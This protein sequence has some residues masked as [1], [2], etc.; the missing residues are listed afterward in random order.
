MLALAAL[1]A[2]SGGGIVRAQQPSSLHADI[3][4]VTTV[5]YPNAR[6]VVDVEDASGGTV[7]QLT[8]ANFTAALDG[9]PVPVVAADLASSQNLPV[10]VLFIM[11]VSGSMAGAPIASAKEAAKAF[12]AGLAPADRVA[13]MSF[14]DDVQLLQDYTTDRGQALAAI[15]GLTAGGNTALYRATD[16]AAHKAAASGASRRVAILLS[17][18]AQDGVP[19]TIT[20]EQALAS[21]AG[22]GTPFFTVGEGREIDRAYLEALAAQTKGRYLEAPSPNDLEGLYASIGQLLR[23]QYVV[24]FDAS[25]AKDGSTFALQLQAGG[26]TATATAPF[27][28]GPGFAPP[29]VTVDG[30]KEGDAL[31]GVRTVTASVGARKDANVTFYVD[32]VSVAEVS[33]PPYRYSLDP[34]RLAAG[35]HRLRV[36]VTDATGT[37]PS[38]ASFGFSWAPPTRAAGGGGLPLLPI[39]AAVLACVVLAL[40]AAV[41]LRL[42][43]MRSHGLE[44]AVR[45]LPWTNPVAEA[46][47]AQEPDVPPAVEPENVGEPLGLLISR[48]GSDFGSEYTVGGSPISIG[49]GARCGV[50]V[51]DPDLGAEEARIWVRKGH[52][53]V[54]RMTKLTTVMNQGGTG[55]WAILE[56]GDSFDIGEHRF[57]FQLLQPEQPEEPAHDIPNVLRDPDVPHR[58]APAGEAAPPPLRSPRTSTFSELMPRNDWGNNAD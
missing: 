20:S 16:E 5:E 28:A 23:S 8:A 4:S 31:S 32:S 45:I 7:Q 55:G 1:I 57:E 10:D 53:M 37:H 35:A 40:I 14:S 22:A 46:P 21:A 41:V 54:H 6:A 49:A 58:V 13:V 48:A 50:R 25:S 9:A 12:V 26:E 2:A 36:V 30:L 18:G 17:D 34:A 39:A 47:R 38:E 19:L 27:K 3:V 42:R 29:P 15:D 44:P 52:L 43:S 33:Q 24:T 11:D 56:P 51:N